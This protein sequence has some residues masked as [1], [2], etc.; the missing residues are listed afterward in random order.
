MSTLFPAKKGLNVKSDLFLYGSP[1]AVRE[2]RGESLADRDHGREV[3]HSAQGSWWGPELFCWCSFPQTA[4][5][6]KRRGIKESNI[7]AAVCRPPALL[8]SQPMG[9]ERRLFYSPHLS[10][11]ARRTALTTLLLCLSFSLSLSHPI[12][13]A[14][15]R[16]PRYCRPLTPLT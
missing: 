13:L 9:S 3:A 5:E 15:F 10:L 2:L 8:Q 4:M 1:Y 6:R 7:S 11:T 16:M 14:L 12:L